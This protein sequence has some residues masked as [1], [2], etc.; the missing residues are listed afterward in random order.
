MAIRQS[1]GNI[2]SVSAGGAD[3]SLGN[4]DNYDLSFLTNNLVRLHIQN[5]GNVGIGTTSPTAKLHVVG[6]ADTEQLIVKA[7]ST[8]TDKIF[9]IQKSDGTV[10]AG[11]DNRGI[12]FSDG[13]SG[14]TNVIIGYNAGSGVIGT[15][16]TVIGSNAGDY[17][18][19]GALSNTLIGSNAGRYM[20]T[21]D[22]NVGLGYSTLSAY[23]GTGIRNLAIGTAALTAN[24]SGS[25]NTAIGVNSGLANTTGSENIFI[26][27]YSA[28]R[29][30]TLSNLLI[31][32]NQQYADAATE[33]SNS[34]LYGVMAAA[35]ANQ[36]LQVNALLNVTGDVRPVTDNT[37]YLGKN[38]D[39]TPAAWK[40]VILKD[41]TDGKYYRI[42]VTNG[43]VEAIDLTD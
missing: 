16:N 22:D 3:R 4:T 35:P 27:Y 20:T 8:Q 39:D 17:L 5:D 34:I 31:I 18:T 10:Y 30:T 28:S 29:Q 13:G 2:I 33:L 21:G 25:R 19:A 42:Q 6:N 15:G 37:Y 12:L 36:T 23:E 14:T 1:R 43:A 7:H 9:E 26:G 40:G 24:T 32:A 38:D 41:T 11:A